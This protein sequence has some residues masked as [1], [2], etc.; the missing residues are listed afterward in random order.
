MPSDIE[1]AERAFKR[2]DFRQTRRRARAVLSMID[3]AE[4]DDATESGRQ[5]AR[6]LLARTSSDRVVLVL[7]AACV[8]F[9]LVIVL[10]YAGTG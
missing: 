6:D 4:T 5:R 2:G 1:D 8:V 10:S 3:A 9:F 7:L